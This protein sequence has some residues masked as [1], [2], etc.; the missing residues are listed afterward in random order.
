[1][2]YEPFFRDYSPVLLGRA[3]VKPAEA[4]PT[5]RSSVASACGYNRRCT[6]SCFD[7]V[8]QWFCTII[9]AND[10]ASSI[11]NC[12]KPYAVKHKILHRY[13]L[14][15]DDSTVGQLT[16]ITKSKNRFFEY[17]ESIYSL[18]GINLNAFKTRFF[19]IIIIVSKFY[20]IWEIQLH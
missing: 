4:T 11:N 5:L 17:F 10:F 19:C 12:A 9:S 6:S 18:K 13:W 7:F 14:V 15:V 16:K 8:H 2:V 20:K 3:S 1:M